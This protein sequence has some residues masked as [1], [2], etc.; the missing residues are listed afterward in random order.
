MFRLP[1][2]D[3]AWPGSATIRLPTGEVWCHPVRWTYLDDDEINRLLAISGSALLRR[4]M[5]GWEGIEDEDG[6]AIPF[7][8]QNLDRLCKVPYWRTAAVDAY[9]RSVAGLPEK[10]SA[11]PPAIGCEAAAENLTSSPKTS[12]P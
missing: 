6:S 3:F 5:V 12:M 8:A 1:A 7:S 9:L 2:A 4:A 10:N 11:T